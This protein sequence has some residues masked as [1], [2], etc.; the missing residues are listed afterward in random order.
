MVEV[1][2]WVDNQ[3]QELWEKTLFFYFLH[4]LKNLIET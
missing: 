2:S 3:V 4:H 1:I